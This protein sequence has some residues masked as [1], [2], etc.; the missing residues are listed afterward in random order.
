MLSA[1]MSANL[2]SRLLILGALALCAHQLEFEHRSRSD[3]M[4]ARSERL[5]IEVRSLK[6]CTQVIFPSIVQIV[7]KDFPLMLNSKDIQLFIQKRDPFPVICVQEH[8]TKRKHWKSIRNQ[9]IKLIIISIV[10]YVISNQN[11]VQSFGITEKSIRKVC[12]LSMNVLF[13]TKNLLPK[14]TLIFI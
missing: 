11:S 13:V 9:Y 3:Q 2:R 10:N 8:I 7:P 1:K 6:L 12:F 4:N 14:V 5:S